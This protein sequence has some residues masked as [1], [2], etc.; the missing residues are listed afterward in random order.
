LQKVKALIP[1]YQS[2]EDP[3]FSKLFAAAMQPIVDA[4]SEK[5][6]G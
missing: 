4:I 2:S 1:N 5:D 6:K 3:G